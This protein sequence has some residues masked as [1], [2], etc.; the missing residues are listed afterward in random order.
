MTHKPPSIKFHPNQVILHFGSPF[1]ISEFQTRIRNQ[2]LQNSLSTKFHPNPL[3]F[4][5]LV[6]PCEFPNFEDRSVISDP[7]NSRV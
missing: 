4:C 7:K 6:R 2:R 5:I 1:L 3:T